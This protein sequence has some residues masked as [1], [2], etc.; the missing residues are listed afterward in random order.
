MYSQSHCFRFFTQ[1]SIGRCY[2]IRTAFMCF[3]NIISRNNLF[4]I[5]EYFLCTLIISLRY[6]FFGKLRKK[7]AMIP[8]RA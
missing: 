4:R 7:P 3:G 8:T 6:Q 5:S 2:I 1:S